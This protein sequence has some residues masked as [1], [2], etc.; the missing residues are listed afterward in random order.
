MQIPRD[1]LPPAMSNGEPRSPGGHELTA[2][3]EVVEC[4]FLG[5]QDR[6]DLSLAMVGRDANANADRGITSAG[7]SRRVGVTCAPHE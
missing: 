5:M 2:V 6:T 3:P 7:S 1:V 4:V